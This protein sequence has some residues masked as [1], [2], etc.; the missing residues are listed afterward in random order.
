VVPAT[1]GVTSRDIRWGQALIAKT[2]S[3]GTR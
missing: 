2:F 1:A 3:A